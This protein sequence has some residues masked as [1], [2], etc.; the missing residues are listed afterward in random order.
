MCDVYPSVYIFLEGGG[1]GA[2]KKIYWILQ[3]IY[4]CTYGFCEVLKSSV[5]SSSKM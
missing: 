2:W 1:V 5:K 3:Y 4:M